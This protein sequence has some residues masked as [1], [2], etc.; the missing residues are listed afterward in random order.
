[1]NQF[2]IQLPNQKTHSIFNYPKRKILSIFNYPKS[3]FDD[4]YSIFNY[5]I[6]KNRY[7]IRYSTTLLGFFSNLLLLNRQHFTL[8]RYLTTQKKGF[9]RYLTTQDLDI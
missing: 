6:K 2:D 1:M 4:F 9:S 5:P 8:V 7:F 3:Y